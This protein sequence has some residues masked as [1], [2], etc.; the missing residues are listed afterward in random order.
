[1]FNMFKKENKPQKNQSIEKLKTDIARLKIKLQEKEKQLDEAVQRKR[2]EKEASRD[3]NAEKRVTKALKRVLVNLDHIY[4]YV[5]PDTTIVNLPLLHTAY[6]EV[7]NLFTS[8]LDKDLLK[9]EKKHPYFGN[10][11]EIKISFPSSN[12]PN[13]EE[14]MKLSAG[15]DLTHDRCRV[16]ADC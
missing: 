6:R 1:M 2:A 4:I 12:L 11:Q 7:Y 14:G 5:Y 10:V 8:L 16:Q 13:F 3:K 9:I 15:V